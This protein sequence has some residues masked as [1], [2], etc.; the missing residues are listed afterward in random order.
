MSELT[1]VLVPLVTIAALVVCVR[2]GDTWPWALVIFFT[3]PIGGIVYLI[4][5][6]GGLQARSLADRRKTT[7]AS[8]ERARSDAA[9][10]DS[11]GAWEELAALAFDRGRYEE[12]AD[13]AQRALAKQ[14][15]DLEGLYLL[16][17][18]LLGA[19]RAQEAVAPL[20]QVVAKKPEHSSGEARFALGVAR[21]R[22]GDAAGARR[23]LEQLAERSSRA[24]FLFELAEAQLATGDP[25]AAKVSLRRIVD[26]F[27]F[28]PKFSRARV[29][30]W[31]WRA[32]WK[33]FR[34][35]S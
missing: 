12:A 20:E 5:T 22:S 31:V 3:A 16:G 27:V 1:Y 17:R 26:E 35:G 14:P 33:L 15:D 30:P 32:Q 10:V 11:A 18:A 8:L 21:Q 24:D 6:F 25:A 29:R 28:V 34:L 7:R 13:A 9:R 23:E 19:G 4:V 2:R